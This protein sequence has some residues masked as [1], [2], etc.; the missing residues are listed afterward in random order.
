[1]QVHAT[2][3]GTYTDGKKAG[4]GKMTYPNGDEYTGEWKDNHM[5]GEGT[6]VYKVLIHLVSKFST[7]LDRAGVNEWARNYM[8]RTK[9]LSSARF[10]YILSDIY[11]GSWV[12]NKKSG[13][14]MY[15]FGADDS[16]MHGT[17]V[18]GTI[19]EGTWVFKVDFENA[20]GFR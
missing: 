16:T 1:D 14:G 10:F 20:N 17:W 18:E 15:Q 5:E 8:K 7:H 13:Q 6:Y 4:T 11:S 3:E 2:F 12:A 9:V 19:T